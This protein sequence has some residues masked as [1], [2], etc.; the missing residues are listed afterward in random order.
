MFY[1]KE[2]SSISNQSV[3][4]YKGNVHIK[5]RKKT[6]CLFFY[7]IGC[8]YLNENINDLRAL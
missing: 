2:L 7:I 5:C 1:F 4:S 6:Y 8:V 3:G